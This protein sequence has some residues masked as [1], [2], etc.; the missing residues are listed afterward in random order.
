MVKNPSAN[1]GEFRF[2][3][4]V[5]KIPWTRKW[6][7]TSVFLPGKSQEESGRR[8][9]MG[10]LKSRTWLS[11]YTTTSLGINGQTVVP[12]LCSGTDQKK[13][14]ESTALSWTWQWIWTC[15]TWRLLLMWVVVEM[16]TSTEY[17]PWQEI[18]VVHFYVHI[19]YNPL[20]EKEFKNLYWYNYID[21][22]SKNSFFNRTPIDKFREKFTVGISIVKID[23][24]GKN[25]QRMLKL[26]S[27][28]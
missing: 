7:P 15:S 20:N 23:D 12:V 27:N 26:L 1:A 28:I 21:K 2:Y 5:R 18:W 19:K 4:W 6:Q 17:I 13:P 22:W 9:P 10:S 3:S 24:S 16:P 8:Q 11:N 14:W 25:H